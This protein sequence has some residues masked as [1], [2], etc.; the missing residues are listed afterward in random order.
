MDKK[1]IKIIMRLII[2]LTILILL[3]NLYMNYSRFINTGE[4]LIRSQGSWFYN[5]LDSFV[6]YL[7]PSLLNMLKSGMIMTGFIIFYIVI[8]WDEITRGD[9]I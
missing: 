9:K 5:G 4:N 3:G 7:L 6:E 1:T 8:P 2:I